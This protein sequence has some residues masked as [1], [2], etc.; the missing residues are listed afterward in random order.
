MF[1][2]INGINNKIYI[3]TYNS[4]SNKL[5][6]KVEKIE[7]RDR[8]EISTVGKTLKNYSLNTDINNLNKIAELR[9]SIQSGTY[10]IDAKLT[11][12]SILYAMKENK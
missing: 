2:S 10:N 6:D 8:I 9:N 1:M 7:S 4:S 3:N 5:I 12:Q 11:A